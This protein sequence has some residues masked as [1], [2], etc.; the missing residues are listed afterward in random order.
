MVRNLVEPRNILA[1]LLGSAEPGLKNTDI[2]ISATYN[3]KCNICTPTTLEP[4]KL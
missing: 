2:D 4:L 3:K 1:E